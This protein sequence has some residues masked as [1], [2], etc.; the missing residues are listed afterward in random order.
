MNFDEILLTFRDYVRKY[1]TTKYDVKTIVLGN[2][3][4]ILRRYDLCTEIFKH[5]QYKKTKQNT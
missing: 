5:F 3:S 4:R 1:S 2:F